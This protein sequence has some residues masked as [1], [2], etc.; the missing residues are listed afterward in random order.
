MIFNKRKIKFLVVGGWNTIFGFIAFIVLYKIFSRI[1]TVQYFAYTSAQIIGTPLAIINAYIGHKIFTFQSKVKGKKM[2]YEF[3][4][5]STT[6][7][8][9]FLLSLF[10]MP[11]T[12]EVLNIQPIISAMILNIVVIITSY[13]G[14]SKFT[15]VNKLK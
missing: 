12:V 6:Y 13:I 7:A 4:R 3:L 14:H 5:F 10:I 8:S 1:F 15:F 9:I 2:I 11:F